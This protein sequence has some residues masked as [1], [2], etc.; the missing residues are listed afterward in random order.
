MNI[1]IFGGTNF[2]GRHICEQA[3]KEGHDVT[4]FNRGTSNPHLFLNHEKIKHIRANREGEL[5]NSLFESYDRVI[6]CSGHFPHWVSK[7]CEALKN[8]TSHYI[9]ISSV[10]VYQDFS[11]DKIFESSST[12]EIGEDLLSSSP[13]TYGSRKKACEEVVLENFGDQATIIRPGLIVGPNDQTWRFLYWLERFSKGGEVLVPDFLDESIQFISVKDLARFLIKESFSDDPVIMNSV[14]PRER[15]TFGDFLKLMTDY[16]QSDCQVFKASEK[17]LLDNKVSPWSELPLW[18]PSSMMGIHRV[19]GKAAIKAGLR[20][21]EPLEVIKET[22]EWF[23]SESSHK[24]DRGG[25]SCE[26]EKLLLD[27]LRSR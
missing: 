16:F 9:Y 19:D 26:D 20:F 7:S 23:S 3:T 27:K 6:D 11:L 22:W 21:T 18:V 15:V 4:L 14:G 12:V 10:S 17:F 2:L 1:L 13:E 24:P 8:R 25:L 5:D